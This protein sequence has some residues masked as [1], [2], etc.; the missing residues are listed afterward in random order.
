M[1]IVDSPAI[2]GK[3]SFYVG[4]RSPLMPKSLIK[5]P[6]GAV[7]PEGWLRKQLELMSEG[8]TGRLPELSEFCKTEN[9]AWLD[10]NGIG[11]HGWE[12]VPYWLKGFIDLGYV[13]GNERIIQESRRWI[14]GILSS[15]RPDGYFGPQSNRDAMD[16]WPNMIA[17]YALRTFYEATG[18]KRVIPFM[19]RYF[20]W[21]M[22]VPFDQLLHGSW[23]KVR[24]G[25]NLD[26]IYWLYNHTGEKWLLDAARVNHERTADWTGGIASLHGVN[27][28]QCFREP[29][30]FYQQTGDIRYLQAAERNYNVMYD[31]YGQVPGGGFAADENARPGYTGPRQGTETC[32]WAELMW[33]HE[34]LASITG[35]IKWLDRCEEVAFNS[36]PASM[37]PD[38]KGLHYLTCP[39]QVQLD[40]ENKAP[41]IQNSGNMFA[42]DP[43]GFRCC[44]HNVAFAW[45]YFTEHLWAAT[46]G[47]GLAAAMY[48]PCTVRAK[49]GDGL[50][51]SITESTDY[52]FSD[53]IVFT[54]ESPKPMRFPLYLRVP[55]WCPNP[56]LN[57][58]GRN[59]SLPAPTKGW[60]CIDKTWA[61]KETIRLVLPMEI[62][63]KRWEKNR[64]TASVYRGP[65]AYSLKIGEE[66]KRYGGTDEWPA[67][68][69]FP[70][71]PWN[72]G[73]VLDEHE[74]EKSFQVAAVRKLGLEQPFTPE[75]APIV[76]KARAKKI[77]QWKLEQNGLIGEVQQSP[78][79]SDEP[80]EEIVLIPMGCARLRVSAFP[81]IGE[82]PDAVEWQEQNA[83]QDANK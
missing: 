58:N 26:S 21:Q 47:N 51:V 7:K 6:P 33:S 32:T 56:K 63:V 75:A 3:N 25:D 73:L 74:P 76:I 62:R 52:P 57:V 54:L 53:E 35:D 18:D 36:L 83:G 28:A 48:A 44:Q 43:Y 5:L 4:N 31:T 69:V 13:L 29:A 2:K 79:R 49:V 38:L 11:E 22:T 55:G 19:T 37:T 45:P 24:G 27:F 23:Q 39:N 20:K 82:G 59:V 14:E 12:E 40:K 15:Q 9:N 67:Y 16:L 50:V 1:K 80:V 71:T 72:Y 41:M 81:V 60:I 30:Q 17:L 78:V 66:W 61:E 70:T 46:P 42:Y 65:L 10:P 8:F 77:P 68:E 64:N 34:M